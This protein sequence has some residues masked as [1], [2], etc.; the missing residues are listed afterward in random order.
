[1]DQTMCRFDMAPKS[2]N[3][4]RNER[5]VHI[6]STGGS[7]RGFTV[8]LSATAS[9]HKK[10]AFIVFKEREGIIPPRV[11]ANLRI[12]RNVIVS[13]SLNGWMTGTLMNQWVNR[14][15]GPNVDDVKRLLVLDRARIHTM[16]A[17]K[18]ALTDRNTDYAYIPGK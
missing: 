4:V 16:N 17:T 9:G 6:A 15:W 8:A 3:H 12:P 11:Y 10:P 13:A 1:M 7:K 2:T 14:V 18:E 5:S